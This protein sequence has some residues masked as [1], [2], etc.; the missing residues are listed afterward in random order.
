MKK[1]TITKAVMVSLVSA[2][3]ASGTVTA[4]AKSHGYKCYGVAKAGKTRCGSAHHACA[5]MAKKDYQPDEWK[6]V[7]IKAKCRKLQK[8]VRAMQDK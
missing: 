6:Y 5:G 2:T 3:L 7:K 4:L 8:N 1:S